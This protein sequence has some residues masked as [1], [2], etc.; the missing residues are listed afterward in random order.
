MTQQTMEVQ[1]SASGKLSTAL[2]LL[3]VTTVLLDLM[4]GGTVSPPL[5]TGI[6]YVTA[7][8]TAVA[9]LQYMY[10]G[11]AWLQRQD[12]ASSTKPTQH[13]QPGRRRA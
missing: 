8:V 12:P 11:L 1:P 10:R 6:F 5:K 13:D 4:Q 7:V 2:Q 3:S 9:G